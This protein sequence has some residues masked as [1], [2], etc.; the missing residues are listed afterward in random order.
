MVL[1]FTWNGV[2]YKEAGGAYLE[3]L[4][5]AIIP[6]STAI[7]TY[8]QRHTYIHMS[9]SPYPPIHRGQIQS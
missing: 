8:T 4:R 6:L 9:I 7:T 3:E 2:S 5:L 1:V